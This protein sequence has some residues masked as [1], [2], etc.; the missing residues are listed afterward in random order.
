MCYIRIARLLFVLLVSNAVFGQNSF[1]T[2]FEPDISL[3][4]KI[5]PNYSHNLKIS[6]RSF[7]YDD[8]LEYR[9]RQVDI[10]HFSNLR[11]QANQS[12]AIGIQYRSRDLFERGLENELRITQQFNTTH[13]KGAIRFG[14][15]L[16]AEQRI[17]PTLTTHR[18][19]YRFA[20]DLPLNGEKLD[21]G[22]SYLVASTE[23]LFSV[24][25]SNSPE[26]DQRISLN[27][28]W[29]LNADT[30]V[31]TGIEYRAENYGQKTENVL[32]LLTSL[33]FSL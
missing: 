26:F 9:P 19:R 4:Y 3:N 22:E 30:K 25:K 18:F 10:S 15:R 27:I 12:L 14:N 23:S 29:L 8:Q 6:Q 16:R 32:F 31:Q 5:T 2:F 20:I 21:V 13:Q 11:I 7:V 1:T 28:G 17:T 24:A 33:I